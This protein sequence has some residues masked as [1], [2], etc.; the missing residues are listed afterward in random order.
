MKYIAHERI[1]YYA[2]DIEVFVDSRLKYLPYAQAGIKW[3]T[4]G[5]VEL[6]SYSTLVLRF[7][8]TGRYQTIEILFDPS[9][10]RT[11]CR[12][13]SAFL[14]QFAP[15]TSYQE[16]KNAFKNGVSMVRKDSVTGEIFAL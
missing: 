15:W 4:G 6:Y 8:N 5:G 7:D 11:T 1:G 14:E 10:S 16:L 9:Y 12:H 2:K 13:V 3:S